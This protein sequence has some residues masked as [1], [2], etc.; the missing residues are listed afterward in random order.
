LR[1]VG[2]WIFS[3]TITLWVVNVLDRKIDTKAFGSD[4]KFFGGV[5]MSL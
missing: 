1:V 2:A 5:T 3:S 4:L